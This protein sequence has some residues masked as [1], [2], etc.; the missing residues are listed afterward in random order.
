MNVPILQKGKLRL[1]KIPVSPGS[2]SLVAD[3]GS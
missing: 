2:P 3:L 1:G